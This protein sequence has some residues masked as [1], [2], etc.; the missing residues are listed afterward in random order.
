[1]IGLTPQQAIATGKFASF[2]L[3]AGAIAAFKRRMLE[4]KRLSIFIIVL[5]TVSGLAASFLLRSIDN[6]S[7]QRLMGLL[8]LGMVPL[9][10]HKNNGL[11]KRTPTKLSRIIGSVALAVILLLQGILSGGIGSLVAG[12]MIIF[13]GLTALEANVMKRKSSI[14]LNL[15]VVLSLLGSGLINFKLG[16]FGMAGG[17]L[18]GYIGSRTALKKGESFAR[19]ALILFMSVSGVW[20]L[21]SA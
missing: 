14:V 18:G 19:Y 13:F 21:A 8:M 11:R 20:L 2:G 17:L 4:D 9:M 5:A 1:M 12:I 10:L 7:L 6:E 15:V 16:L 3:S